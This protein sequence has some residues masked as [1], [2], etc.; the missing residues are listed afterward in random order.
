MASTIPNTIQ[1]QP[2]P[3]YPATAHQ[4]PARAKPHATNPEDT[5]HLSAAAQQATRAPAKPATK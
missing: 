4:K 2:V 3:Q 1:T 5:V